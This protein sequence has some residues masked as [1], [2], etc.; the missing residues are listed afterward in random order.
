MAGEAGRIF[1]MSVLH[2]TMSSGTYDLFRSFFFSMLH[3]KSEN[4]AFSG[5][6]VTGNVRSNDCPGL[7]IVRPGQFFVQYFSTW[8]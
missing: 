4:A 7:Y 6:G 3:L 5:Q 2:R 8:K 1:F